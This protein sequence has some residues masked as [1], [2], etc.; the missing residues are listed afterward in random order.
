MSL[1]RTFLPITNG[2]QPLLICLII[3]PLVYEPP[4]YKVY[5]GYIVFAFSVRMF[6]CL[7]VC[8]L[9]S[10]VKNFSGTI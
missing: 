5:K 3:I 7:S 4:L 2:G 10:S 6:V 8:K 1:Q 9:F